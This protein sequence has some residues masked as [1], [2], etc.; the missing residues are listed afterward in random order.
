MHAPLAPCPRL[1]TL[2]RLVPPFPFC[3]G[4]SGRL[5]S[6]SN[7]VSRGLE[8]HASSS[9]FVRRARPRWTRQ[10]RLAFALWV[11]LWAAR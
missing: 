4:L 10:A 5:V 2:F 11:K 6:M 1:S 9:V 3:P 7:G 8:M